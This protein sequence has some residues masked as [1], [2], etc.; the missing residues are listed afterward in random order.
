MVD[1]ARA[2]LEGKAPSSRPPSSALASPTWSLDRL[3]GEIT[4]D[5]RT[6]PLTEGGGEFSFG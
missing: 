5:G 4:A 3:A 1:Y 2:P 6:E